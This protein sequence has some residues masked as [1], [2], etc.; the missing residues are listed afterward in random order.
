M[1]VRQR[2]TDGGRAYVGAKQDSSGGDLEGVVG[3]HAI[4]LGQVAVKFKK[5]N[6][7]HRLH[8]CAK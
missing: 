5:R 1:K 2:E 8:F 7:D 3:S 6:W 4:R